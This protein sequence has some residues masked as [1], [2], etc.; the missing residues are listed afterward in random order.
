M[1]DRSQPVQPPFAVQPIVRQAPEIFDSSNNSFVVHPNRFVASGRTTGMVPVTS[2]PINVNAPSYTENR[3]RR[4]VSDS[5]EGSNDSSD[6]SSASGRRS[7]S[8]R[9]MR[10]R[11]RMNS[12]RDFV[13]TRP[14]TS[15][16][17]PKISSIRQIGT[18]HSAEA[19]A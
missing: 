16:F 12:F 2:A 13:R 3:H 11:M 1:N 5:S 19:W 14:F 9:L 18:N 17:C 7:M 8:R 6:A 10:S 15:S 4:Q